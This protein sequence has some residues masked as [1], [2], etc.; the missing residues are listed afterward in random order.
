MLDPLRP[1][2]EIPEDMLDGGALDFELRKAD[3]PDDTADPI[4][5]P[6]ACKY[7]LVLLAA[8]VSCD[9]APILR[10]TAPKPVRSPDASPVGFTVVSP[11]AP[12][13]ESVRGASS[14]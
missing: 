10:F 7:P 8:P 5:P 6:P 9:Q 1:V 4:T 2:E 3:Q 14:E 13:C 12:I 11:L